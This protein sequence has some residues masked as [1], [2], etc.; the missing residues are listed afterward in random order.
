V[1]TGLEISEFGIFPQNKNLRLGCRIS[2]VF[3][4]RDLRAQTLEGQ[5]I[6]VVFPD[7]TKYFLASSGAG[8]F[9]TPSAEEMKNWAARLNEAPGFPA[10]TVYR[11]PHTF[12]NTSAG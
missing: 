2:L 5:A 4:L 11:D 1:A 12:S 10:V 9:E 8:V 6:A 3:Q 7:V